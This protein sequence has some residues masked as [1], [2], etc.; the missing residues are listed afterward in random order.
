[1]ILNI[2]EGKRTCRLIASLNREMEYIAPINNLVRTLRV[3][4]DQLL[5][6]PEMIGFLPGHLQ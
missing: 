6:I 1:M 4:G 3:S 2:I 5:N